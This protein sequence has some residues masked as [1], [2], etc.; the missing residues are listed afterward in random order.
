MS[1]IKDIIPEKDWR[2]VKIQ[3]YPAI[4][5]DRNVPSEYFLNGMSDA[6]KELEKHSIETIVPSLY[7]GW[8]NY[9]DSFQPLTLIREGKKRTLY[10]TLNGL[11]AAAKYICALPVQD[12]P[13]KHVLAVAYGGPTGSCNV[14]VPTN[15]DVY[16]DPFKVNLV[17]I[18]LSWYVD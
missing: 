13:K 8:A 3:D 14:V 16:I 6:V 10:G 9:A 12:R 7:S 11:Q 15:G 1:D 4:P 2:K 17:G 18:N 5:T